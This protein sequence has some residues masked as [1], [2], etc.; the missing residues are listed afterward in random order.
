MRADSELVF[1]NSVECLEGDTKPHQLSENNWEGK[2]LKILKNGKG[3]A[4]ACELFSDTKGNKLDG[5]KDGNLSGH[6]SSECLSDKIKEAGDPGKGD[7]LGKE[8]SV[9]YMDKNVM[10]C[11]LPEIV[12]CYEEKT[13]HVVKDIC[14]DEG[15]PLQKFLSKKIDSDQFGSE[16]S[17]EAEV[18]V[19]VLTGPMTGNLESES[20]DIGPVKAEEDSDFCNASISGSEI[21]TADKKSEGEVKD[22]ANYT[23]VKDMP[24]LDAPGISPESNSDR[25]IGGRGESE[26]LSEMEE[27]KTGGISGKESLT[28]ADVMSMED[29]EKKPFNRNSNGPEEQSSQ[30]SRGKRSSETATLAP[31]VDEMD[32]SKTVEALSTVMADAEAYETEKAKNGEEETSSCIENAEVTVH[33]LGST[34]REATKTTRTGEPQRSES[35]SYVSRHK[36]TLEDPTDHPFP[37]GSGIGETSFSAAEPVSGHITYSGPISFS[38]SLSVRSDGSTTST[39]SFAFPVLQTEW[40]SSPVRMAK[41]DR[42]HLR[43]QKSW[44]HSLLCCRF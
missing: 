18:N 8:R 31:E 13:C 9:F 41:A 33:S 7:S 11:D 23:I 34:S 37:S 30:E 28:L 44:K 42:R 4:H 10:D 17:M 2:E 35:E 26:D 1:G 22:D 19:D 27:V 20:L 39:R 12:A 15:V 5:E 21:L 25:H 32:D 16:D 6:R 43:S 29:G 24:A 14:V 40:N 38:G 36:F 3:N